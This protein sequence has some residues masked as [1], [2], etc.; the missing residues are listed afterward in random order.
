[1]RFPSSN[2][3][4]TCTAARGKFS[5]YLDGQISGLE[6]ASMAAHLDTCSNCGR[7]FAALRAMQSTL[8]EMN[9][10][11]APPRLQ[12]RLRAAIAQERERETHLPPFRRWLRSWQTDIAPM[13][14]R[15]TGA[16]AIA[17]TLVAGLSWMFAAPLAVEAND[18][19]MANLTAPRYL[20]SPVPPRP[21]ITQN[22]A[23]IVVEAQVDASGR[24]YDFTILAGPNDEA[25]KQQVTENL[26]G[27]I[28]KPAEAFGI[29]VNG[30]VMLT[31][32]GISVRG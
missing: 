23:P 15:A 5:A 11:A 31:F 20:Y 4:L 13:A 21:F 24:V 1:M 19:K 2:S 7:E 9:P 30:H 26:L 16:L 17:M 29:P 28:F 10:V 25:V 14:L 18:D 32:S 3:R 8:A 27:S 6:M 22:D 12:A